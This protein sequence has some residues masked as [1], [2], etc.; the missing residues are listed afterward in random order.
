L[1]SHAWSP[2]RVD[3]RANVRLLSPPF[4]A[5][6]AG[7]GVDT[8]VQRRF[9]T[10]VCELYNANCRSCVLCVFFLLFRHRLLHHALGPAWIHL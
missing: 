1:E 6:F 9:C 4:A 7:T 3:R 8:L 2:R 10:V 5:P